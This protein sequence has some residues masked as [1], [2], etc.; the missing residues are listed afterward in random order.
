[1]DGLS[2]H[3]GLSWAA[4]YIQPRQIIIKRKDILFSMFPPGFLK[5]LFETPGFV[6]ELFRATLIN[7][8]L[9]IGALLFF[10]FSYGKR[11]FSKRRKNHIKVALIYSRLNKSVLS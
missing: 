3:A 5:N 7:L 9:I 1:M 4:T 6:L 2:T 10:S 8:T 11:A